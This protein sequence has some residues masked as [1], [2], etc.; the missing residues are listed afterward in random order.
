MDLATFAPATPTAPPL[1]PALQ[2]RVDALLD[3]TRRQLSEILSGGKAVGPRPAM[4]TLEDA[5]A[6][7]AGPLRTTHS[8]LAHRWRRGEYPLPDLWS[9]SGRRMKRKIVVPALWVD[10]AL[11]DGPAA[12]TRRVQPHEIR[13]YLSVWPDPMSVKVC[14]HAIGIGETTAKRLANEGVLPVTRTGDGLV[15]RHHALAEY[16]A[17]CISEAIDEW[18]PPGVL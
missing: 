14:A 2:L 5:C 16:L 1:D 10:L 9:G 3:S 18:A 12:F 13:R 15:V 4:L 7:L 6:I 11:R 17:R 8:G